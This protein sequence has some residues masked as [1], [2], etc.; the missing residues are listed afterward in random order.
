M[1]SFV[2]FSIKTMI[3]KEKVGKIFSYGRAHIE[4]PPEFHQILHDELCR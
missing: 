2:Y 1:E 3:R 4:S